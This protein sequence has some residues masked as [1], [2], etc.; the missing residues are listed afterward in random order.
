G[1]QRLQ[2]AGVTGLPPA[3]HRER[4]RKVFAQDA[5]AHGSAF[6]TSEP[7]PEVLERRPSFGGFGYRSM[8][9]R[10]KPIVTAWVRSFAASL[11]RMFLTWPLTVS[12]VMES[13]AAIILLA[14]PP[15]MSLST[16]ISRSDN[17]SSAACSANV[18]APSGTIRLW[19]A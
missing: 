12:S 14:F 10:F 17:V 16:S 13:R 11:A 3:V 5:C 1:G 15:A 19:P 4:S 6:K 18:V 7:A 8:I 2:R 9:P